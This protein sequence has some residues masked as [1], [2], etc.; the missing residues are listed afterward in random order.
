MSF[1]EVARRA[2][3]DLREARGV[4][5]EAAF[6][7]FQRAVPRRRRAHRTAAMCGIAAALIVAM[8]GSRWLMPDGSRNTQPAP[9]PVETTA[10][11]TVDTGS[12]SGCDHRWV[13]CHGGRHYTVW[14]TVPMDWTIPHEFEAPYSGAAPT[15]SRV[16]TYTQTAGGGG[17]TVLENVSAATSEPFP[18]AV[19][20]VVSAESF[21]NWLTG[22]PFFSSSQLHTGRIDGRPAWIVD[23]VVGPGEPAGPASCNRTTA[24]YPTMLQGDHVI[25]AW[26]GLTSRYTILDL[27]GAGITVVWSWGLDG[28]VP[29]AAVKVTDGIRFH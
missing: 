2:G 21:A 28:E 18:A 15:T 7:E 9:Q 16:E 12:G 14:L 17:V 4:D 29:P 25:G 3:H 26:A 6:A 23:A 22:R 10:P 20:A 11:P 24:C 27:P 19:S 5:V 8:A 1:E 13:D